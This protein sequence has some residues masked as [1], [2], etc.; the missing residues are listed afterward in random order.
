MRIIVAGIHTGV[1]KTLTSAILTQVLNAEY[2]KPIQAGS[3]DFTDTD[4]VRKLTGAKCHPES[5]CF[6]HSLS[7]HLSARLEN[8]SIDENK[9]RIP[10]T[11]SHLIIETF[12]GF[13]SPCTTQILQGDLLS[14][15][16]CQ[17]VLVSSHYLGS[18]NH[19][20]LTLEAMTMRNLDIL[21]LVLNQ[22]PRKEQEDIIELSKLPLI[23]A[24]QHEH[25]IS[26]ERVLYYASL[27]KKNLNLLDNVC[28]P[29]LKR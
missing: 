6:A 17:W 14:T 29:I 4:F 26:K 5:Y 28:S 7:P 13:L 23:G 27:W 21:G 3:L 22:Y 1:G 12:G 18:I 15:W 10:E 9:I 19:T 16:P 8:T 2:W 11:P 20:F 24:I 25:S